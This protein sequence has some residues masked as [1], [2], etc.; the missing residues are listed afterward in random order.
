MSAEGE[1]AEQG[2][3][4]PPSR[5]PGFLVPRAGRAGPWGGRVG[6]LNAY[7]RCSSL[8]GDRVRSAPVKD[9]ARGLREKVPPRFELGSLDSESR[10]LIITPWKHRRLALRGSTGRPAARAQDLPPARRSGHPAVSRF[11]RGPRPSLQVWTLSKELKSIW[12][13]RQ[14]GAFRPPLNAPILWP[15][16]L[17]FSALR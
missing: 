7:L 17:E 8:S 1:A 11:L 6:P 10:V 15:A 16:F 14:G 9:P 13:E 12:G 4:G 2:G 5:D 3:P